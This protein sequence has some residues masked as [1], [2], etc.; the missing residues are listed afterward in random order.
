MGHTLKCVSERCAL[1]EDKNKAQSVY[2]ESGINLPARVVQ[3][4]GPKQTDDEAFRE[5]VQKYNLT[6][7]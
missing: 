4:Q 2:E 1:T 7:I 6:F 5:F 3:N